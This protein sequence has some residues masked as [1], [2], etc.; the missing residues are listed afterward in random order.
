MNYLF[1]KHYAHDIPSKCAIFCA[2]VLS[3]SVAWSEF[4]SCLNCM[5][6]KSIT[7][8]TIRKIELKSS[9]FMPIMFI[10]LI[11]AWNSALSS[12]PGG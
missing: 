12:M 7:E 8:E 5:E 4:L 6:P 10:D 3:G 11:V 1:F 9:L 2:T